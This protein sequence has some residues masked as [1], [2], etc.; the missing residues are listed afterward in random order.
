[1]SAIRLQA[2][3]EH[4]LRQAWGARVV[5]YLLGASVAHA[6]AFLTTV[7]MVAA[8]LIAAWVLP[9]LALSGAVRIAEALRQR[10]AAGRP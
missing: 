5:L 9:I 7:V 10:R 4:L 3:L 6:A 8:F 2:A 1:M